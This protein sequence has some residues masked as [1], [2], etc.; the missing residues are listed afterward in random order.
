M[1]CTSCEKEVDP[2]IYLASDGPHYGK[3]VCPECRKFLQWIPKPKNEGKRPKNK[4]DPTSLNIFACEICG[5]DSLRIGQYESLEVH[6]K[7]PIEEGGEDKREN[8]LVVCTACHR[9][10]HWLRT[11]LNR[12]LLDD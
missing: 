8:L 11:Y 3:A 9:L 7:I 10:C 1:F 12:H 5:R 2:D 4:F 6:H